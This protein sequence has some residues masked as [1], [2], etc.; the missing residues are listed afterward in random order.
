MAAD[1]FD[2]AAYCDQYLDTTAVADFTANGLQVEGG[3]EVRRIV[4]GVTACQALLDQAVAEEADLVLV[5]HGYFWKGEDPQLVGMK[6]RRIRTLMM[7]GMS[8]LAYHLPLDRHPEVGNNAVLA[9]LLGITPTEPF[10]DLNGATI[11]LG[12]ELAA[13]QAPEVLVEQVASALGSSPLHVAGPQS[14]IHRVALC[15]G[16]APDLLPEA[17]EAGFDLFIT[18]ESN[19]RVTHMARE[20]GIH[21]LA[22]G[23]H[24]TERG[25]PR[26][27]GEHLAER[28]HLEHRF[29]DIPNP[30]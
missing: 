18:G 15:S 23:H 8:L 4:S 22:A 7:A 19:E 3:R 25:G 13:P 12:G 30:A 24:A 28:F 5:H 16:G 10:G 27:L 11:G 29:V 26:A 6:G 20:M 17:A 1:L 2:L 9:H 14:S 21:F